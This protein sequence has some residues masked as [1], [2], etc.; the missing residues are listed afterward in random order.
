[1]QG[2]ERYCIKCGH[3]CHCYQPTCEECVNDVCTGCDCE[4][5][6]EQPNT[7]TDA[8]S[9]KDFLKF[10]YS[11]EELKNSDIHFLAHDDQLHQEMKRFRNHDQLWKSHERNQSTTSKQNS[12][13][14][15]NDNPMPKNGKT[16]RFSIFRW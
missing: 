7:D 15:K 10:S 16:F 8:R 2:P 11:E 9:L 4:E 12:Q 5:D 14:G 3:R 6:N 13:G 1:M